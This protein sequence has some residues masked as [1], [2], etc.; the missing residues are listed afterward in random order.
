MFGEGLPH[1]RPTDAFDQR[2]LAGERIL[3]VEVS[4]EGKRHL[5]VVQ[6]IPAPSDYHGTNRL[7]CHAVPDGTGGAV[8]LTFALDAMDEEIKTSL[9]SQGFYPIVIS[10][11]GF[12]LV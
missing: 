3:E 7:Q 12:L 5:T 1:E 2:A 9:L 4:G 10:V 8:R 6:P 11:A